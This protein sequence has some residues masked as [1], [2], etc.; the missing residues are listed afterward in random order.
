[1]NESKNTTNLLFS[2]FLSFLQSLPFVFFLSLFCFWRFRLFKLFKSSNFIYFLC[3]L[4]LNGLM[5][6]IHKS[7]QSPETILPPSQNLVDNPHLLH[8]FFI[9]FLALCLFFF[10]CLV[11]FW[12]HFLGRFY[13]PQESIKYAHIKCL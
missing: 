12:Y 9:L 13:I 7:H 8:Y 5:H 10:K 11:S 2:F 1:M 3:S 4:D 6:S